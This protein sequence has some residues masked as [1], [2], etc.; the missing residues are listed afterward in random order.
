MTDFNIAELNVARLKHDI[1]DPRISDF[2]RNLNRINFAAERSE[3]FVWRLKDEAGSSVAMSAEN[4][5][6][7]IPNLSVW[8]DV[9]SLENF[10][11]K[12]VHKRF[13]ERRAEWFSVMEKMHFVMWMLPEGHQ[14]SLEEAWDRL[15]HLNSH[16][17]SDHA[18]GWEHVDGANLWRTAR[19]TTP[20]A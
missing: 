13:Y 7:V 17:A 15:N 18:F 10:V 5:P 19:C 9:K 4:D 12:T 6:M 3:G 11:F 2:V 16:G 8:T 20:A 1:N 14:P